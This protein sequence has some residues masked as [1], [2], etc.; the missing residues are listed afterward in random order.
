ME[1]P[2][3]DRLPYEPPLIAEIGDFTTETRGAGGLLPDY[4][5]G[6]PH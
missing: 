1:A 3:I 2:E 5:G 6:I 4:W